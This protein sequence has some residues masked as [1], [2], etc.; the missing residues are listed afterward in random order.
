MG[1]VWQRLLNGRLSPA[2]AAERKWLWHGYL[3]AG[4]ITLLTSQWKSGKTTLIAVLLARMGKG[5]QLAERPVSPARVAVLSEEAA[6]NW[7][8]RCRKLQI[9]DHVCFLCRPV[10]CLPTPSD[11]RDLVNAM[12][13]LRRDEGVDLVV[14]DSLVRFLPAG[15]ESQASNMMDALLALGD[16]TGEGLAVLLVHHPRKGAHL[17][18]QAARGTGALPSHADIVLEMDWYGRPDDEDRRRWLRAYSRHE[19]TP[20]H[21]ILELNEAGDDYRVYT[22]PPTGESLETWQ[23]LRS[24]LLDANQPLT[25]REILS[26]WPEDFAKPNVGTISRGLK[27]GQEQGLIRQRGAG[28]KREPFRYWLPEREEELFGKK[29]G[30]P[31]AMPA[32]EPVLP[33]PPASPGNLETRTEPTRPEIPPAPAPAPPPNR[34]AA[35][36]A[37]STDEAER[38]RLRR[39]PYG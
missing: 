39:W 22:A 19:E 34:P 17:P 32:P 7:A 8:E 12:L 6:D 24:V 5:G 33:P 31:A 13:A 10:P 16:L 36:R 11:W 1:I 29:T 4:K 25:Q 20:R 37:P 3:A 18:G 23:V 38:R 14:I 15:S 28:S 35:L 26:D 30:E 2:A 21:L 9:G 27:R